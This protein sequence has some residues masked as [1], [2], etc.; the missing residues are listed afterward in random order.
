MKCDAIGY[1]SATLQRS[2]KKSRR[3]TDRNCGNSKIEREKEEEE[4][5]ISGM[6]ETHNKVGVAIDKEI[7]I[8]LDHLI[9]STAIYLT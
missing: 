1:F 8:K 7:E 3:K 6:G 4:E 2:H 9:D 5:E